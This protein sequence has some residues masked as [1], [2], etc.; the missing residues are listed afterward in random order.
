MKKENKNSRTRNYCTLVYPESAPENWRD[1]LADYK[2]PAIISPLHDRDINP[3]GEIKKAH[4]H[5]ILMFGSVK[6]WQQAKDIFV[7]FGGVGCEVVVTIRGAVRYLCHLDNPEKAQYSQSDVKCLC[8]A[9][10]YELVNLASDKYKCISEMMDFCTANDVFEMFELMEYAR[11]ERPDWFRF[12]CDNSTLVIKE[13][14]KSARFCYAKRRR[15]LVE[16]PCTNY[17][18]TE[19]KKEIGGIK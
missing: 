15:Q 1:I 16:A 12:L 13:Y 19:V 4:Y 2:V 8:G 11:A 5:V 7:T 3:G 6:S 18:A 17:I 9:D 10:Y 14:L